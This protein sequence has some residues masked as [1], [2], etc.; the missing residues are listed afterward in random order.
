VTVYCV[1]Y[2]L[3][4]AGQ[5]YNALYEELKKAGT[6]WHYLDSTWLIDTS[7]TAQSLSD[8]LLKHIDSNDRLLVIKVT[9]DYQGYLPK[10]AWDWINQRVV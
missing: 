2:D 6:W 4:K 7:L 10:E 1:S 9:R 8:R 5:N 3:N